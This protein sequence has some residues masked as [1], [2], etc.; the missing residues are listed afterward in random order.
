MRPPTVRLAEAR[1][2]GLR[3]LILTGSL[4]HIGLSATSKRTRPS[5]GWHWSRARS[6]PCAVYPWLLSGLF[7]MNSTRIGMSSVSNPPN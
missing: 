3:V 5:P 2:P 7:S 1:H 6:K 4:P